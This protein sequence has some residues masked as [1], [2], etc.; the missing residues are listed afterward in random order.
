MTYFEFIDEEYHKDCD[1]RRYQCQK[2][3]K[4]VKKSFIRNH[5]LNECQ[6][7]NAQCDYCKADL[8][9]NDEDIKAHLMKCDVAK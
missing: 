4:V 8:G 6:A 3:K 7:S 1:Y 2:C 9:P 5:L